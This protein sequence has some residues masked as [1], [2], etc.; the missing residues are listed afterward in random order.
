MEIIGPQKIYEGDRLFLT[1]S[2]NGSLPRVNYVN[3]L[4]KQGT[5]FLSEEYPK[6]NHSL[7]VLAEGQTDFNCELDMGR[8]VKMTSKNISVAGKLLCRV[9]IIVNGHFLTQAY[10]AFTDISWLIND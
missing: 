5:R 8:V 10:M 3:L 2:I 1:C 9:F 4:L 6:V 7:V